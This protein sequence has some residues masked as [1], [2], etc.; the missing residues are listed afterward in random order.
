MK[1]TRERI[2]G[3]KSIPL[4]LFFSEEQKARIAQAIYARLLEN[5]AM[6]GYSDYEWAD[7][8]LFYWRFFVKEYLRKV[9]GGNE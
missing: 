2:L 8:E 5:D 7:A 4:S 6:V 1:R 9:E 3:R